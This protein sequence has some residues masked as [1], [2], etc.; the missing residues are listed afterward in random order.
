MSTSAIGTVLDAIRAALVLRVGLLDV[1]VFSG[2]VPLET[3]GLECI[4]FGDGKLKEAEDT[5]GGNREETWEVEGETCANKSW[6]G[7][8]E[9]T[10][11]AARDRAVAL[12]AELES[13]LNDTYD[14]DY[15]N[16]DLTAGEMVQ[17]FTAEGRRCSIYFTL[18]VTAHKNP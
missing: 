11:K 12:L 5:M 15:P 16:V 2:P 18:T 17:E 1:N 9:A 4:A 13:H 14:G 7:T 6:E 10:I 3:A 8:V